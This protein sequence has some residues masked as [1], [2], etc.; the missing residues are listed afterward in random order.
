MWPAAPAMGRG[1]FNIADEDGYHNCFYFLLRNTMRFV[2]GSQIWTERCR[3]G[4]FK[5]HDYKFVVEGSN[6]PQHTVRWYDAEGNV[7][8]ITGDGVKETGV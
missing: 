8:R 3:C 5:Q 4:R 6:S 7:D 2:S 1:N